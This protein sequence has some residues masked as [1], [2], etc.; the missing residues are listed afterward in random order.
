MLHQDRI[1]EKIILHPGFSGPQLA[2]NDVAILTLKN[3][4]EL[5]HHI[6]T[7]CLPNQLSNTHISLKNCIATGWGKS[8][9]GSDSEYQVI[10]K[11][12]EMDMVDHKDC[13]NKLRKTR[14]GPRFN[15]DESFNCA[16]SKT[17]VDTCTGDG[18]GPL[19]CPGDDF[20]NISGAESTTKT[21]Y[22]VRNQL[23][24]FNKQFLTRL[25]RLSILSP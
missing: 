22:Q 1:V 9:F 2:H 14:L 6:D 5:D 21:Y 17:G 10:L 7:I 18:G 20:I 3:P 4:F 16:G 12:I 25:K 23:N 24:A 8:K 13:E 15:L 19:V 11:E